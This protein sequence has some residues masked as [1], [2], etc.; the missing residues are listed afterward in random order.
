MPVALCAALALAAAEPDRD[1]AQQQKWIAAARAQAKK[2]KELAFGMQSAAAVKAFEEALVL[3]G[4]GAPAL[5]SFV[6]YAQ[7]LVDLGAALSDAGREKEADDV[8]RRALVMETGVDMP[9]DQYAPSILKR[10]KRAKADLARQMRSSITVTGRPEGATVFW[11][12]R[13]VGAL[14]ITISDAVP[15]EHWLTAQH[16]GKKRFSTL[17]QVK[18]KLERIEVFMV[19]AAGAQPP[20]PTTAPT[21]PVT[22]L[23]TAVPQTTVPPPRAEQPL[24]VKVAPKQIHPVVALL[25]FGIGQFAA[26]RYLPGALL[27]VTE[28]GLIATNL[29]L[30]FLA[31]SYRQPD[32]TYNDASRAFTLAVVADVALG[33]FIAEAIAGAI[34][35]LVHRDVV[36]P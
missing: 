1:L 3:F 10:F 28:V 5:D 4:R 8:F 9:P 29:A 33:A 14:P 22:A 32:G 7:C 6:E 30:F 12:G 13:R 2:A 23:Q 35:G 16:P 20:A 11:D 27:L 34:D 15:G 18:N 24:V 36:E 31:R 25:P 26:K 21:Q 17:I 19:D